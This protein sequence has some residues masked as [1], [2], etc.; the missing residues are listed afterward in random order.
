MMINLTRLTTLL[1]CLTIAACSSTP[2]TPPTG[3]LPPLDPNEGKQTLFPTPQAAVDAV[4]A[5]CTANDTEALIRIFGSNYRDE[6]VSG[7]PEQAKRN[8]ADFHERATAMM[9][10]DE[11]DE[12]TRELIVGIQKWPFSILL[13]KEAGDWRFDTSEGVE[14]ILDRRVGRGEL[15]AIAVCRAYIDAQGEYAASDR[16]GDEVREYAQRMV[17]SPGKRDGLYWPVE[18]DSDEPLSP[19]GPLAAKAEVD[20]DT[21]KPGVPLHGYYFRILTRQGSAAPGGAYSYII[22]GN[23]IG[24][25]ALLAWPAEYGNSGVMTFIISHQGRVYEKDLGEAT[26]RIA[27]KLKVYNPDD[28][29][30]LV[31]EP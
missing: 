10:I 4:L 8:R 1:A 11:I 5:A 19:L 16:D 20:P 18:P 14:E 29:W 22:N 21:R 15:T 23:M 13:V 7:D 2:T 31:D 24:G 27:G 12:N 26:A 3:A 17:S 28:T 25:C 9:S 30:S 6:I